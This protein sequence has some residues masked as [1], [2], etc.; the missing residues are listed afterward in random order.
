MR[1]AVLGDG[2]FLAQA[3]AQ[4]VVGAAVYDGNSR[5]YK[6]IPVRATF[7]QTGIMLDPI[8]K[9]NDEGLVHYTFIGP[10]NVTLEPIAPEGF[11]ATEPITVKTKLIKDFKSGIDEAQFYIGRPAQPKFPWV[12]IAIGAGV[13]LV[14][15]LYYRGR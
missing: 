12:P 4:Y 1:V 6:E 3:E 2:S 8:R 15:Y 5:P 13:F 9:T 11:A 14:G 7:H 10:A